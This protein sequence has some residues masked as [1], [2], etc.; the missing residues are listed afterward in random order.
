MY[1]V[2]ENDGLY[3][4]FDDHDEAKECAAKLREFHREE[5]RRPNANFRKM[6]KAEEAEWC[7]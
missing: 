1:A 2:F 3:E 4:M 5:G 7:R 6:T